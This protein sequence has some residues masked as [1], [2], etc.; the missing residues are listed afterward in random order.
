[1]VKV[2]ELIYYLGHGCHNNFVIIDNTKGVYNCDKI[3]NAAYNL[4]LETGR[5]DLLI[6]NSMPAKN[7]AAIFEMLVLEPNFT[8]ADFCGNGAR[9]VGE[10]LF[11][12]YH[13]LQPYF[14]ISSRLGVHKVT[15]L[16][17]HNVS[18]ELPKSSFDVNATKFIENP[19]IFKN[20]TLSKQI[21]DRNFLMYYVESIEPHLVIFEKLSSKTLESIGNYVNFKLGDIFPFGI[22]VNSC[23]EIS[24]GHIFVETYERSLFRLTQSCGTGSISCAQ[25]YSK[26][27]QY[28]DDVNV[29]T[30]GGNINIQTNE[31]TNILIMSGSAEITGGPYTYNFMAKEYAKS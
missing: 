30:N 2:N 7:C 9:L 14:F 19:K 6:I 12:Q 13:S 21:N 23:Y 5:D 28:I 27:R 24:P 1:M 25:L 17:K 29:H 4:L 15:K 8:F 26:L 22:H 3:I 31:E 10:F 20:N 16:Q 18:I 11:K